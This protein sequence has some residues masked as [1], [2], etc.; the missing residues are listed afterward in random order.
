MGLTPLELDPRRISPL[1]EPTSVGRWEVGVH[2][3]PLDL[4]KDF[5]EV[6]GHV[7]TELLALD[8]KGDPLFR[9]TFS[10]MMGGSTGYDAFCNDGAHRMPP[11]YGLPRRSCASTRRWEVSWM[12]MEAIVQHL[13]R[14][15]SEERY[16]L[17][18]FN[19]M[20][21]CWCLLGAAGIDPNDARDPGPRQEVPPRPP[22]NRGIGRRP[23]LW[24][25]T[26]PRLNHRWH[27]ER[28][29]RRAI[30][31]NVGATPHD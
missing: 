11:D 1:P 12:Q 14:V 10:W 4:R 25:R 20:G 15:V 22:T 29:E 3:T 17:L 19:C 6:K 2:A 24:P 5:H 8:P 9:R 16:R 21:F 13:P 28:H 18:Q 31:P 26:I 30:P 27:L 23:P 7:F